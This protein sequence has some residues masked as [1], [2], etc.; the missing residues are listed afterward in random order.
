VS[1]LIASSVWMFPAIP[2]WPSSTLSSNYD[3]HRRLAHLK[4][5]VRARLGLVTR[6]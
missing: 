6:S 3:I 1:D 2:A 5:P 4:S